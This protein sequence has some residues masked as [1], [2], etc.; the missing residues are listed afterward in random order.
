[1]KTRMTLLTGLLLAGFAVLQAAE[2][3]KGNGHIVTR[4]IE[5]SD[6]DEILLAGTV[7]FNYVQSNKAPGLELTIDENLL[8]FV[9]I[10][11]KDRQLVV[12]YK[13][14][15][16]LN[17][18]KSVIR[19]H[20]KWL[21]KAKL[22]GT[23]T[24]CTDAPIEGNELELRTL[25]SGQI[26]IKWPI[27]VYELALIASSSG[28]IVVD[29]VQTDNLE[30]KISSAGNILIGGGQA[31]NATFT[32]NGSGDINSFNCKLQN[33]SGKIAGSGNMN[34]SVTKTLKASVLGSGNIRY[35]GTAVVTSRKL[36]SGSVE[37]AQ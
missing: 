22:T 4:T 32:I 1:M 18:T 10:E 37:R 16:N 8:P 12:D 19:S 33:L 30:C 29:I 34:V 28:G 20:S 35:K 17:P 9:K 2:E 7:D 27:K 31:A 5:I 6:Y 24:F 11:V 13:K 23:G 21:R 26:Q 3:I 25:G 14:G 15:V 36:G